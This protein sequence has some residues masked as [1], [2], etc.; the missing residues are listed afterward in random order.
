MPAGKECHWI[1]VSA[2][3]G[4]G[5]GDVKPLVGLGTVLAK[6]KRMRSASAQPEKQ[7]PAGCWQ[8]LTLTSQPAPALIP[9]SPKL[10]KLSHK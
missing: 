10:E 9:G 1:F 8:L 4:E 6:S 7:K 3:C 5:G 2:G